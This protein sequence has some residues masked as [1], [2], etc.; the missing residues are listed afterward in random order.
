MGNTDG[1]QDVN[2]PDKSPSGDYFSVAVINRV[3]FK[4]QLFPFNTAIS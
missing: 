3:P 1:E 2:L 4:A